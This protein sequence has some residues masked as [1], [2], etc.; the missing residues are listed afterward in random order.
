VDHLDVHSAFLNGDLD[1]E[2]Y[3]SIP[4]HEMACKLNKYLYGL[5]QSS[6]QWSIKLT[7]TLIDFG[8]RRS[9]VDY[10]LFIKTK[11]NS[12]LVVLDFVD[13]LLITG[14]NKEDIH[15]INEYH[16]MK[17]NIK[18]LGQARYFLGLEIER[19]KDGIVVCQ[20]KYCLDLNGS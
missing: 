17:F 10:S 13:D 8:F 3:M 19:S 9:K 2:V 11:P 7:N 6:I 12:F 5:K 20:R 4:Q 1:E 14:D 15:K 16:N 18:D